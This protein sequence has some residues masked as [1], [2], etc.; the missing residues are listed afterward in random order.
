M[1][2]PPARERC[3]VSALD[4]G[5]SAR[6]HDNY[7][8]AP[9]GALEGAAVADVR[10]DPHTRVCAP[11]GGLPQTPAQHIFNDDGLHEPDGPRLE[12]VAGE[13]IDNWLP[14]GLGFEVG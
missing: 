2:P 14:A 6:R 8:R 3:T 11:G 1:E 7:T 10:P 4:T 13:R 12:D 5:R 9:R